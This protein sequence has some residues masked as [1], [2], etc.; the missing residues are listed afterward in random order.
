VSWHHKMSGDMDDGLIGPREFFIL[1]ITCG[2]VYLFKKYQHRLPFVG[3]GF[4]NPFTRDVTAGS[5]NDARREA[6]LAARMR[7]QQDYDKFLEENKEKIKEE[8]AR[9][10]RERQERTSILGKLREEEKRKNMDKSLRAEYNPLMGAGG[11]CG[12][13]P[14]K[15]GPAAG[16]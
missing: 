4:Q 6:M 16:G 14:G 3:S 5:E 12:W 1:I 8:E 11:S 7:M 2:V 15:K 9:K 10:E 13:K